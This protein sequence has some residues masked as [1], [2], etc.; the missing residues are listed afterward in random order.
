MEEHL[1]KRHPSQSFH[2]LVTGK[3]I[4]LGT[5]KGVMARV[6]VQAKGTPPPSGGSSAQQL[7]VFFPAPGPPFP[8]DH[9]LVR[10]VC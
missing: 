4:S 10:R 3:G 5:T 8:T 2:V 9:S 6:F 7:V 1:A